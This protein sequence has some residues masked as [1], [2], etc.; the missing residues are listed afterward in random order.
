M[1]P[2][3]TSPPAASVAVRDVDSLLSEL[4]EAERRRPADASLYGAATP[5]KLE[6]TVRWLQAN[7]RALRRYPDQKMAFQV[8]EWSSVCAPGIHCGARCHQR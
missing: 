8:R 1:R 3:F 6:T 7:M 5:A 4:L 2:P